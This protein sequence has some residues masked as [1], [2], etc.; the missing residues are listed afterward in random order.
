MFADQD[1]SNG[2]VDVAV[3]CYEDP[4]V[5]YNFTMK[6]CDLVK[7]LTT[8]NGYLSCPLK[9]ANY[10]VKYKVPINFGMASVS[11][12]G[13]SSGTVDTA[14]ADIMYGWLVRYL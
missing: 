12:L 3:S 14:V 5:N 10:A 9:Q 1:I 7:K 11:N 2:V 4:P 8:S 13:Y 6:I